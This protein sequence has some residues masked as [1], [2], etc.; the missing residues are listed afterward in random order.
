MRLLHLKTRM[1]GQHD[2]KLAPRQ[3]RKA[4]VLVRIWK[5]LSF[6]ALGGSS[7]QFFEALGSVLETPWDFLKALEIVL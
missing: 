4:K 5:Y 6:G 7:G 1:C 3:P 2:A